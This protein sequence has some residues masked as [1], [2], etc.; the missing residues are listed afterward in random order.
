MEINPNNQDESTGYLLYHLTML[1][2]RKMKR[3]LDKLDITHTQFVILASSYML[4][5]KNE[6]VT[7]IGIANQSKMDKMMVSKVLRTLQS[8]GLI[9]RQE[10]LT[11]TRAKMILLTE[12]GI[13]LF[14]KAFV[15]VKQVE[16]EFFRCL[17]NEIQPFN[18]KI[19]TLLE[20]NQ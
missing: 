9:T 17:E 19:K 4:S 8:K 5:K 3:E 14:Q 15:I 6:S 11:D 18:D 16:K 10:H 13:R 12:D 7:Q 20:N 1:M 2:Q